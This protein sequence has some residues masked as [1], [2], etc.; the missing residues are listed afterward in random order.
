MGAPSLK[1]NK[2][3]N[4]VDTILDTPLDAF[5]WENI[6]KIGDGKVLENKV[7]DYMSKWGGFI[8]GGGREENIWK[9]KKW[10]LWPYIYGWN[11][12]TN[13]I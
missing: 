4:P 5:I 6:F 13:I 9:Q 1:C 3:E 2:I 7:E 12:W 10:G 8:V 11:C